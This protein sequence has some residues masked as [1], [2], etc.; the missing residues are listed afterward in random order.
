[1]CLRNFYKVDSVKVFISIYKCLSSL[2]T[3]GICTHVEIIPATPVTTVK[4]TNIHVSCRVLL[5][6]FFFSADKP[7]KID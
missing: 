3:I 2:L 5:G 6:F 1:M 7:M 4:N